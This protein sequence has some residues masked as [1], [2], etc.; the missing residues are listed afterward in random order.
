MI[1]ADIENFVY[2]AEEALIKVAARVV[3]G[4]LLYRCDDII[5]V[6]T[7]T[8]ARCRKVKRERLVGGF[9]QS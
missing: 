9:S 6:A 8:P 1:Q 5:L 4:E 7:V 2:F 3:F